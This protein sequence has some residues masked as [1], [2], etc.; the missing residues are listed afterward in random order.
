MTDYKRMVSYM[1]QYENGIKKKNVGYVRVE[2]K[3]G[4]CKFTIHM[5]LLGQPDSIFPTYLIQRDNSGHELIYLGDSILKTQLID[6]RFTTEEG[7]IMESGYSLKDLSGVLIFMNNN[8]FFATVWDDKTLDTDELLE[9]MRPKNRRNKKNERYESAV[10]EFDN[11][12]SEESKNFKSALSNDSQNII[13]KSSEKNLTASKEKNDLMADEDSYAFESKSEEETRKLK[14][15]LTANIDNAKSKAA[16]EAIKT[17]NELFKDTQKAAD[18]AYEWQQSFEE[19]LSQE[20]ELK[21]PTYKFPRGLKTVEMFRRTMAAADKVYNSDTASDTSQKE[22]EEAPANPAVKLNQPA[23]PVMKPRV[24]TSTDNKTDNSKMESH[25]NNVSA[26]R[27]KT[28]SEAE[29]TETRMNNTAVNS[30]RQ[31][32]LDSIIT[33]FNRLYPFEDNEILLCVK[34][35]PKDIGLLPKEIWPLSSNSFLLH[36][37]YCYHHLIL[38]KMKY[39]DR[40]IYI[41]GVPGLYQHREQFMARMFGFDHFKSIKK[42]EPRKGDFGYWYLMLNC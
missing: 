16:T 36:G 28:E 29:K 8:I 19:K 30:S 12:T 17:E 1:Y 21:I 3:N 40:A 25:I 42:R 37:Y 24:A 32:N 20:E 33:R 22:N 15:K 34:I 4:Q 35:E 11:K 10:N 23:A 18:E 2:L 6:S 9:A 27:F 41:L 14:D 7:N 26:E 39:K 5:Q 13:E 31:I 38:A